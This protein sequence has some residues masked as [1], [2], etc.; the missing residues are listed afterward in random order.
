[1]NRACSAT[2]QAEEKVIKALHLFFVRRS[3]SRLFCK[4]LTE[5]S[6]TASADFVEGAKVLDDFYIVTRYANGYLTGAPLEH[7]GTIQYSY[8]S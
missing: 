7:H 4:L 1:M 5:L 2:Q 8:H 6:F 3:G